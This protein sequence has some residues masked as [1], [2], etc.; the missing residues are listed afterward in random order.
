MT[1]Q[2][3]RQYERKGIIIAI[4]IH[5]LLLL[6]FFFW[7]VLQQTDA[8]GGGIPGTAINFGFG[9]IGSGDNNSMEEVGTENPQDNPEQVEQ[10]D[11]SQSI[12]APDASSLTTPNPDAETVV[13][14]TQ[15]N[16]ASS[17]S[18]TTSTSTNT[19]TGTSSTQQNASSKSGTTTSGDGV[20]G[21]P[22]NQGNPKGTLDSRNYYGEPGNGGSGNG[23]ALSMDGW[24]LEKE[25]KVENV[26]K[27]AGKV[28]FV[29]KIDNEGEIISLTVKEKQVS[30]ALAK[31][32]EYEIRNKME[33]VKNRNNG[34]TAEVST[35]V[36]TFLFRLN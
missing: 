16:P 36:I 35:G 26:E 10:A 17:T 7:I 23:T 11:A 15:K 3:E 32:C 18:K 9:E 5:S 14:E 30:E 28:T 2:E 4:I 19:Q 24:H 25:P 12:S 21:Q 1:R 13:N 27:E 8:G 29:I 33:F 20:T 6:G 31:K 22:G 34:S